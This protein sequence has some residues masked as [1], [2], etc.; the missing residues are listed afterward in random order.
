G[1][2]PTAEIRALE[3]AI[4]RQ[5]DVG[6]LVP[7]PAEPAAPAST[8][9]SVRLLG[10]TGEL[11]ALER[12]TR[13]ALEGSS[14][15]ILVE[16]EAGVGKTRL[17]DELAISLVGVRIGRASGSELEQHLP[18]VPLAAAVRNA[19]CRLELAGQRWP[20]LA[21]IL[22]EL[23]FDESR[24]PA[25]QLGALEAL[26]ELI[27]EH[28]PV[29]LVIDD[30]QWADSATIAAISYL[31]RRCADVALAVVAGARTEQTPPGHAVRS[32]R[33]DTAIRLEPLTR[34][35]LAPLGIADIYESTGGNPRFV[36]E[37]LATGGGTAA[38]S[39]LA[40]SLRAECRAEG[41]WAYRVLL[42]ASILTQ[43]FE[44]QPLAALLYADPFELAEE[45]ERLCE[46]R[47]LAVDGLGFRFRYELVREVLRSSLSPARRRL[48]EDLLENPR[49]DTGS[50]P[51]GRG[52]ALRAV[53][54]AAHAR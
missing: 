20:A 54:A 25:G 29:V 31:R 38:S 8:A 40:E 16:G 3:S 28:A 42:A 6:S 48:L 47:I 45:L 24:R 5:E 26:A 11:A 17:L 27:A 7:R 44:P 37:A 35:E 4:L 34:A 23:S 18:Y 1:L 46:R 9:R 14:S 22:P 36:A 51:A 13:R 19:I 53:T 49:E 21:R 2:E 12:A 30:V 10:R 50:P 43:P 39:T 15:L 32:L 33:P 41:P 52:Q